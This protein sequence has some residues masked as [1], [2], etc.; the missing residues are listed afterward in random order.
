[1]DLTLKSSKQTKK[2]TAPENDDNFGDGFDSVD[3]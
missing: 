2:K 1:M 3:L